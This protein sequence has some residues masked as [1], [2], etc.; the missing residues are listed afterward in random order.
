[1]KGSTQSI[2]SRIETLEPGTIILP[3]E[4]KDLGA[5]TAVRK[6]LSRLTTSKKIVRMGHGIYA[7]P[8]EDPSLGALLP[9]LEDVAKALA[10]KE[11][12]RIRPTGLYALNRLG[13]S[14]QVPMR[15][16][17]LTS[18]HTKQIRIGKSSI[19]FRSTTAR[20]LSMKGNVSSL[21]LLAMEEINL[22]GMSK[23]MSD[24]IRQLLMKEQKDNLRHDLRQTTSRI[25]DFIIRNYPDVLK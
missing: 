2:E 5:S 6:A 15:L 10:E 20:K 3:S 13:L 18:G 1:M 14:T 19:V 4:F 17:F 16:T 24:R 11:S 7:I 21:L 12:V 25:S 22:E 9:S 8:R 23:S